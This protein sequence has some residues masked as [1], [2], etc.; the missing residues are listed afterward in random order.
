MTKIPEYV[1]R[2]SRTIVKD[3]DDGTFWYNIIDGRTH[4]DSRHVGMTPEN[5]LERIFRDNKPQVSA[6]ACNR[7]MRECITE[8]VLADLPAICEKNRQAG[9]LPYSHSIQLADD[10]YQ[11][12]GDAVNF[13]TRHRGIIRARDGGIREMTSD[14]TT[15][16]LRPDDNSKY[17][18]RLVT[19]FPE[20]SAESV[21]ETGRDLTDT[22]RR[23]RAYRYG[24]ETLRAYMMAATDAIP[25]GFAIAYHP[26]DRGFPDSLSV[27]FPSSNAGTE[28]CV[29]IDEISMNMRTYTYAPDGQRTSTLCTVG[30]RP[31]KRLDLTDEA[32]MAMFAAQYPD[33][34]RYIDKILNRISHEHE[35]IRAERPRRMPN[36]SVPYAPDPQVD[37]DFGD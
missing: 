29:Y 13:K 23:T 26:A 5:M 12:E 6:F 20:M 33:A 18:F 7:D 3:I 16:I 22:C 31:R 15:V 34:A 1:N 9:R 35:L 11:A 24:T 14:V 21:R 28:H 8:C 2:L 25:K 4:V 32:N 10:I 17:G 19:A 36:V 30:G 27:S 37:M